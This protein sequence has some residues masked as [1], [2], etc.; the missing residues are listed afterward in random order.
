MTRP[1]LNEADRLKVS[2]LCDA[3]RRLRDSPAAGGGRLD[4]SLNGDFDFSHTFVR[5]IAQSR[6]V[7]QVGRVR[8]PR[9]VLDA[10]EQFLD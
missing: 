7:G 1:D 3:G 6:A 9:L 8:Y 2:G 10:A 5:G 4:P